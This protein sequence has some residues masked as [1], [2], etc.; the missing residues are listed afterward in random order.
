M[1]LIFFIFSFDTSAVVAQTISRS[2][3]LANAALAQEIEDDLKPLPWAVP[4]Q[5]RAASLI[6]P[7]VKEAKEMS[8]DGPN[9]TFD[10]LRRRVDHDTI[11][12]LTQRPFRFTNMSEVQ[13][14]VLSQMPEVAGIMP[15]PPHGMTPKAWMESMPEGSEERRVLQDKIENGV[16]K[17][18]MLVKAKTGTGKTIV[19]RPTPNSV[20]FNLSLI[21]MSTAIHRPFWYRLSRGGFTISIRRATRAGKILARKLI[22]A[23]KDSSFVSCCKAYGRLKS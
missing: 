7:E 8:N 6:E 16:R 12:A 20:P 19:S 15:R 2:R 4:E 18:D 14:R 9:Y 17:K 21:R 1:M 23:R 3:S 13:Y 10:S 5:P 11:K 22:P